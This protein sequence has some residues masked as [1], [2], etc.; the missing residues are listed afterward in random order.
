MKQL[1]DDRYLTRDVSRCVR[2]WA[3]RSYRIRSR[4][5]R[6]ASVEKDTRV[7]ESKVISMHKVDLH[8]GE[9]VAVRILSFHDGNV[10][11]A[12]RWLGDLRAKMRRQKA[13]APSIYKFIEEHRPLIEESYQ[14]MR[15]WWH[16]AAY[17]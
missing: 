4:S 9:S 1:T 6:R 14:I 7:R 13:K 16:A 15:E 17:R 2:M 10:G 8:T 12:F 11:N 5:E 3:N